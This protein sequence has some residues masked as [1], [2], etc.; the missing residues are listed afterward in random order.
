MG[1]VGVT[2]ELE[3]QLRW[4]E[5]VENVGMIFRKSFWGLKKCDRVYDACHRVCQLDVGISTK[6]YIVCDWCQGRQAV[7]A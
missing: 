5:G 1:S 7:E 2:C 4:A 3:A 6:T